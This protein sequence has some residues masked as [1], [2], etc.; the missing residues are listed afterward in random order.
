[1]RSTAGNRLTLETL[2]P[3]DIFGALAAMGIDAD[4]RGD[5]AVAL[6]PNPKHDDHSPSWSCNL[7]DGR[8]H[9]FVCGFGGSFVYLVTKMLGVPT[10]DASQWV[11]GR[12]IKDV[13]EGFIGPRPQAVKRAA[14]I[15]EA[16]LWR[17]TDPPAEALASRGLDS[18]ACK[19]YDVRWDAE[20]DYWITTVRDPVTGKLWGWQEKNAKHFRNRPL[21]VQKSRALFGYREMVPG[22]TALVVESPLDVPY[23][24]H[25]VDPGVFPVSSYGVSVSREQ[26]ALLRSRAGRVVLALDNDRAGWQGVSRLAFAFGT[27]PVLVFDYGTATRL[28]THADIAEPDG[29]D[30]GNLTADE[31]AWGVQHAIPAWEVKI[32]WL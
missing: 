18:G 19:K 11:R 13:A 17:F 25:Q 32:H 9:C 23:V 31:L 2:V 22:G 7:D 24:H 12:K 27:T 26:V 20:H 8:H 14:G 21:D 10:P 29:R 15:S 1:M 28:A 4:E 3:R 16:D 30:P 6:C 5:E